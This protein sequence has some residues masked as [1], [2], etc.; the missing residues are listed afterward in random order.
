MDGENSLISGHKIN[1]LDYFILKLLELM[2]TP[3]EQIVGS[4]VILTSAT[5]D[6]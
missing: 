6:L 5:V 3:K 2:N 1:I 4:S